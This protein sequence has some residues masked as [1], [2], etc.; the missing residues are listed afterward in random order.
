MLI[1]NKL[2]I[3][4]DHK[5]VY[6]EVQYSIS[7]RPISTFYTATG[8]MA[9]GTEII[10]EEKKF[11]GRFQ[12]AWNYNRDNYEDATIGEIKEADDRKAWNSANKTNVGKNW[13]D[14]V[15]SIE[16]IQ[17]L[18]TRA[19]KACMSRNRDLDGDGLITY[20]AN[21]PS[22]NEVRWYLAGI[23]QYR[24]LT[25]GQTSLDVD[26]RL[27]N[28]T[29]LG[30]IASSIKSKPGHNERVPYHYFTC[31]GGIKT[32]FWPEESLTNNPTDSWS[33]AELVRC[34]RTLESGSIDKPAYGTK[35]HE[36]YYTPEKDKITLNNVEYTR[37][38]FI[39]NGIESTRGPIINEPTP[40]HN[41]IENFNN[42]S[43]CFVVAVKDLNVNEGD[44]DNY[45]NRFNYSNIT[46][47][48]D[49]FCYEHYAEGD[50]GIHTWRTPNQKEFA[51]MISEMDE[52][53]DEDD[54]QYGIRTKF[55]GWDKARGYWDWHNETDGIWC[56][57]GRINV[58]RGGMQ[59]GGLKIRCVRDKIL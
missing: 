27:M 12:A 34:V 18:Y 51:L 50:Y 57:K 17:P 46:G 59:T 45:P 3:S 32:T 2:N 56:D 33:R 40:V 48:T 39:L 6:A 23:E 1:A 41:E 29:D 9:L 24:A 8:L 54:D 19:A 52:L 5:S 26:A 13:Y 43:S 35:E 47:A 42:L 4:T 16:N 10:D 20:N 44:F 15:K 31:S 36:L 7:Q 21:N 28:E 25:Y 30:I 38:T 58:G 37:Y 22:K 53:E 11:N 14:N 55:S 49:D